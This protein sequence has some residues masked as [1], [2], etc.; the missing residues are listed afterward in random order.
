MTAHIPEARRIQEAYPE[1]QQPESLPPEVTD[2]FEKLS[3]AAERFEAAMTRARQFKE[4]PAVL[5]GLRELVNIMG[6]DVPD[7]GGDIR[8]FSA[9]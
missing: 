6:V 1:L 7:A 4:D 5:K 8:L 3:I 9:P 2:N